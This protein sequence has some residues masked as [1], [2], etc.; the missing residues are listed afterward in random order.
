MSLI[1]SDGASCAIVHA[2]LTSVP[3]PLSPKSLIFASDGHTG[4][5]G[6]L[7]LAQA[8]TCSSDGH[9]ENREALSLSQA[10]TCLSEGYTESRE[11]LP[12]SQANTC[13]GLC[14]IDHVDDPDCCLMDMGVN[15]HTCSANGIQL[16]LMDA[17]QFRLNFLLYATK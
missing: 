10:S 1:A 12:L 14:S 7:P 3:L 8:S 2:P 9:T 13:S 6:E 4:S 16:C 15:M 5:R 11:V 17:R